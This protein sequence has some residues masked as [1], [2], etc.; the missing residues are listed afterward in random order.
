MDKIRKCLV[1]LFAM[2]TSSHASPQPV[3]RGATIFIGRQEWMTENLDVDHYLDGTPIQEAKTAAEW[4]ICNQNRIGCYCN[5][6]N[7]SCYG[8]MYG[9]LYNWYAVRRGIAPHC[10]RI[11]S[12]ADFDRL[13]AYLGATEAGKKLKAKHSW[14]NDWNGLNI[15]GFNGLA[16]GCRN[17]T[18]TFSYVSKEAFWWTCDARKTADERGTGLSFFVNYDDKIDYQITE[19]YGYS[20]RCM[21]DKGEP[22][23]NPCP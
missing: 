17:P 6:D 16:S 13:V 11:P 19:D 23:P 7:E 12:K 14:S 1:F 21:R 5:Y 10:W 18:G 9:K 20:V 2:L 3:T 4:K 22:P 8:S 15:S